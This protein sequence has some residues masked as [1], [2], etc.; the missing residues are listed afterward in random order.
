MSREIIIREVGPRDGLQNEPGFLPTPLKIELIK[1]LAAAGLPEIEVTSFV[2]PKWVPQFA[3]QKEVAAAVHDLKGVRL[4]ALVPNAKGYESFRQ[5]PLAEAC[6]F[7]GASETFNKKNVNCSIKEHIDAFAGVLDAIHADGTHSLAYLSTVCGCPYEGEISVDQVL[8]VIER[9]TGFERISLGDTIGI[10]RPEQVADL[11]RRVGAV[12]PIE[13]IAWH[14]HDTYERALANAQAAYEEGVR[15]F[16]SSIGGL[17]GCPFAPG[18]KGNL[19]T[20]KLVEHFTTK[21]GIELAPLKGITD[22]LHEGIKADENHK[23]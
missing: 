21:T 12:Y 4:S 15:I 23:Y 11:V 3:D 17:G 14:G 20:E 18:A 13:R 16:D 5:H 6:F 7:V 9:L 1:K 22:W 8:R 10:G 2:S 19:A